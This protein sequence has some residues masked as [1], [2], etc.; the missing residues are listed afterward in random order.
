MAAQ[1][2]AAVFC[3]VCEQP[4]VTAT[5]LRQRWEWMK[6]EAQVNDILNIT[7]QYI[8]DTYTACRVCQRDPPNMLCSTCKPSYTCKCGNART[9]CPRH[10]DA[11][12]WCNAAVCIAANC[13]AYCSVTACGRP[14]CKHC[15]TKHACLRCRNR[16]HCKMHLVKC[17]MD[18]CGRSM[19]TSH[20]RVCDGCKSTVCY[21]HRR[22]C[23]TLGCS[24]YVCP[25]CAIECS[26]CGSLNCNDREHT[27]WCA[28]PNC[29]N[30][31]CRSPVHDNMDCVMCNMPYCVTHH[32]TFEHGCMPSYL[33][34]TEEQNAIESGA[35][36]TAP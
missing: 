15:A 36:P 18:L 13:A 1:A 21:V 24:L 35:S 20:G 10:T 8:N 2:E 5:N 26:W 30:R 27:R 4:R 31:T 12:S 32:L 7:H 17:E 25:A 29:N 11:C 19:C 16:L 28:M 23:Q 9:T 33:T 34:E 3:C 22:V 14:I 6:K